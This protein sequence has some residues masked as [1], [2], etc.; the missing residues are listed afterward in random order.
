[1]SSY[2]GLPTAPKQ[3]QS[4]PSSY[5]IN[6][7]LSQ[8]QVTRP[9]PL[10]VISRAMS[11]N[12]YYP[13]TSLK[14]HSDTISNSDND[15]SGYTFNTHPPVDDFTWG[16]TSGIYTPVL[17]MQMNTPSSIHRLTPSPT[18]SDGSYSNEYS[19]YNSDSE[20]NGNS[21]TYTLPSEYS[22][23]SL[24]SLSPLFTLQARD[25]SS[26]PHISPIKS[27]PALSA[28]SALS[29]L[30]SSSPR[31]ATPTTPGSAAQS[32]FPPTPGSATQS[33]FMPSPTMSDMNNMLLLE[34]QGT[35]EPERQRY[36]HREQLQLFRNALNLPNDGAGPFVPQLMYR[37]HTT[38]DRKR[39]V[40]E[41]LLEAPIYFYTE[42]SGR[43]GISLQDALHS[44]TKNLVDRDQTVFEGRGPSVSIRLE[45]PGYRQWSRQI[46]TKDFRS[47]PGPITIAKLAKNVAKC[48]LRF[49]QDRK[50]HPMEDESDQRWRI[51]DGP[52]DIKLDD[53]VLVSIHHV[54][55]G[56]WQP[57]LRLRRP[58]QITAASRP[59]ARNPV[60]NGSSAMMNYPQRP[61][62]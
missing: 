45:W 55:L 26:L 58:R 62:S 13:H 61:V 25:R 21:S 14:Q 7:W 12:P 6:H 29:S 28:L 16:P 36:T 38:S 5:P 2:N 59:A 3:P 18:Y 8:Q 32:S 23:D 35:V 42:H 34:A 54:S 4:A 17:Q 47:P 24:V 53:L 57:H 39:Y 19:P 10:Q 50:A 40:E 1:M 60:S 56:S 46:P 11:N 41:V 27:D 31:V 15:S 33:S 30:Y 20:Y 22:P 49:I 51:G 52:N 44:R 9:I 48:V 43:C 37:P